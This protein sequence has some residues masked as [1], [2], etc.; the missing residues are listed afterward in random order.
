MPAI[1]AFIIACLLA[2]NPAWGWESYI[3]RGLSGT[4]L[5]ILEGNIFTVR[6]R[7][8]KEMAIRFYGIGIPTARQPFGREAHNALAELLPPGSRPAITIVNEGGEGIYSALVQVN[9]RSVN[10]LLVSQGLAW[11]DRHT[12]KAFFCRRWH[13]EE[14]IAQQERKGVWSINVSTPPWQWGEPKAN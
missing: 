14:H 11:V 5:E 1:L 9:D 3:G 8:G 4:V 10:N 2:P 7:D 13:I 6:A 12:C